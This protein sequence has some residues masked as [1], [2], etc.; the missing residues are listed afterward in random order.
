MRTESEC[1]HGRGSK[2]E[3]GHVGG[4]RGREFRRRARVR[5]HRSTVGVA[6]AELTGRVYGAEREREKGA[7]GQR[8]CVWQ[9]GPA[10]QREKRDARGRSN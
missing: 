2:R 4:R 1:G 10:R 7:R 3:L 8:F 6:K 5:M 9:R